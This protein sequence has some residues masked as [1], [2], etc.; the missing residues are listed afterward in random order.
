[1]LLEFLSALFVHP[2]TENLA[3]LTQ[4]TEESKRNK[5]NFTFPTQTVNVIEL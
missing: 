1:M 2:G 4:K 3:C 5:G